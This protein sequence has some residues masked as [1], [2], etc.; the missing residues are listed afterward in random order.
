M[1]VKRFNKTRFIIFIIIVI[2][3]ITLIV[4]GIVSLINFINYRKSNE[5]KL[6]TRG[7]D[8]T[9]VKVLIDK[10][11]QKEID[12]LLKRKNDD[13]IVEFVKQG[14]FIY[15]NL[16]KYIEYQKRN[17]KEDKSRIVAIINT[18]ANIDWFDTEKETNIEDK[19]LML[20]NRLYGLSSDYVPD[21]I[22]SIPV[23][24]AY[25]GKKISKSILENIEKLCDD[26]SEEGYTFVVSEGY[27]SYKEQ[28]KLYDYYASNF[29]RSEADKVA[30]RP[31]HSEYQT[32]I[33][34][35]LKPYNKTF[36]DPKKSEEYNWLRDNA[37]KYGFILR[38]S[39]EKEYLTG[40]E[41]NVW[42]LRYVGDA[43]DT[44]AEEDLCLEEYY[45]YYYLRRDNNE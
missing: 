24:Y 34:F 44:I 15:E 31:G 12:E 25:S 33:T 39:K 29:S 18:E 42:K 1:A 26:A 30:A 3:V 37:Y 32:G 8:E 27:R 7:Y 11:N 14:Y 23:K 41:E 17:K 35:D 20:V 16:D 10:L 21:D 4:Y 38:L 22:V 6:L 40:F 9:Q 45:A 19:E 43:A 28:K 36:K 5:F 2:V 13:I